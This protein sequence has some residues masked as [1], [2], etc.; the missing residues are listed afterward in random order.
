MSDIQTTLN[1]YQYDKVAAVN[2][3]FNLLVQAGIG[4]NPQTITDAAVA[5]LDAC[6]G[7]PETSREAAMLI[8]RILQVPQSAIDNLYID[9]LGMSA[10]KAQHLT[11]SE[12]ARRYAEYKRSKSK[13]LTGW[14]SSDMQKLNEEDKYIKRF[15]KRIAERMAEMSDEDLQRNYDEFPEDRERRKMVGKEIAERMGGKD[16]YGNPQTAYGV[17]YAETR[18]YTDLAEDVL[19]QTEQKKA[20]QNG[21]TEREKDINKARNRINKLKESLPETPF[22]LEDGTKVT[23]EDI[24]NEIRELRS[25]YLKEFGIKK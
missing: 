1:H 25:E 22:T 16:S 13:P 24:M 5:I 3:V 12:M 10:D 11:I 6:D 14:I 18:N 4:T 8:M 20:K 15:G 19:L 9:E 7:E 21:E 2:D 17:V 23:K